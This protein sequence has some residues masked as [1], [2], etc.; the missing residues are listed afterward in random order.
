[1]S[2]V[3]V[4]QKYEQTNA[5]GK[6]FVWLRHLAFRPRFKRLLCNS[7]DIRAHGLVG[8]RGAVRGPMVSRLAA[9]VGVVG[10]PA[11]W[12]VADLAMCRRAFGQAA[13]GIRAAPVA[14]SM[15]CFFSMAIQRGAFR[16]TI[17]AS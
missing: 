11:L 15:W 7:S 9:K 6:E 10:C 1:M 16:L 5:E 4:V 8:R 3:Q 2:T 14:G 13:T 17:I 12:P